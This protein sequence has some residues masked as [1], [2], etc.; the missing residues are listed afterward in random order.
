LHGVDL[1][2]GML[3]RAQALCDRSGWHNATLIRCE[4]SK[5]SLPGLVDAVLFSLS[6]SVILDHLAALQHAWMHLRPG[7]SMVILDGKLHRGILGK[8]LGPIGVFLSKAPC[9]GILT[10]DRGMT[11][12]HS[13]M[14]SG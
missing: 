9:S 10:S 12:G 1:S 5:Y 11:C 13:R 14:T 8:L 7:G 6:Y 2:E 3:A 4:A